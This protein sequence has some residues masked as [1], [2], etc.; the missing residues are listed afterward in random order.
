M[1]IKEGHVLPIYTYRKVSVSP[2]TVQVTQMAAVITQGHLE[3]GN[4]QM[5]AAAVGAGFQY[6]SKARQGR[7]LSLLPPL[8]SSVTSAKSCILKSS[9]FLRNM[10][11]RSQAKLTELLR[12]LSKLSEVLGT[13]LSVWAGKLSKRDL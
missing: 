5:E 9:V 6:K 10:D 11:R 7:S 1:E 4:Y 3:S 12:D 2:C 8:L 13:L